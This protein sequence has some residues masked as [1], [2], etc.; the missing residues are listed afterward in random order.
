MKN[1]QDFQQS[2]IKKY[3]G[4]IDTV[5]EETQKEDDTSFTLSISSNIENIMKKKSK[6]SC[7]N[8]QK[9]LNLSKRDDNSERDNKQ[10]AV[11]KQEDK[12]KC[13]KAQAKEEQNSKHTIKERE[14]DWICF[15]CKNHNFSFRIKCNRC[16]IFKTESEYL[17]VK[18]F[19]N[20]GI[21][22][23]V[24]SDNT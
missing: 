5:S 23:N 14:G 1:L 22:S 16:D 11:N 6:N 21:Y 2:Y 8:K 12:S 15:V 3:K 10:V 17:R 19:T 24:I 13:N 9:E 18:N 7:K 4:N 20:K